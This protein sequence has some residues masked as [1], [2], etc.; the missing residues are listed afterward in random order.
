M[1]PHLLSTAAPI[2]KNIFAIPPT[3]FRPI[4]R[5]KTEKKTPPENFFAHGGNNFSVFFSP[6]PRPKYTKEASWELIQPNS[7]KT[8][9]KLKKTRKKIKKGVDKRGGEWYNIK[10]VR[11]SGCE[12]I[13]N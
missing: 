9:K 7:K 1:E 13:E 3:P 12:V 2:K 11:E 5:F 8:R 4:C 6:K 10:A